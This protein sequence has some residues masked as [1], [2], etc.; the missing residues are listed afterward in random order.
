[1]TLEAEIGSAIQGGAASGT[2][3][4]MQRQ[5]TRFRPASSLSIGCAIT[6]PL[7]AP[8][9]LA[10]RTRGSASRIPATVTVP[11]LVSANCW[12]AVGRDTEATLLHAEQVY[13]RKAAEVARHAALRPKPKE[14]DD[15]GAIGSALILAL[16]QSKAITPSQSA[17]GRRGRCK[18]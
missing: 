18:R 9:A 12:I 14:I 15:G 4:T 16:Q 7:M 8:C 3:G 17:F 10:Y 5:S 2:L 11:L 1:M 13:G 6:A